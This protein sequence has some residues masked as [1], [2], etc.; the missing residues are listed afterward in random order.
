MYK[1]FF[2]FAFSLVGTLKDAN[3]MLNGLGYNEFRRDKTRHEGERRDEKDEE[4]GAEMSNSPP[5]SLP[6]PALPHLLKRS[7]SQISS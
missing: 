2:P 1:T 4:K 6:Q 3:C 7:P 5:S